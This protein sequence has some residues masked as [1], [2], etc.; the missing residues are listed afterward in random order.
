MDSIIRG[1]YQPLEKLGSG[2]MGDV[3]KA[4]DLKLNRMVALKFLRADHSGDPTRRQ[5]FMQ[6]AQAASA[7]N[8]PNIITIHDVI[9]E[10]DADIMVMEMVSG[11]TLDA[12]IPR[13]GL[14]VS[15]I[16]NY[17]A[18]VADAL[19]AAHGAG[20]IHRDLKPG[21]IMVTERDLVKLLDFGLAKLAPGAFAEDPEATG[22]T[23]LTVQGTIVG[24][25][26]YM[27]PE[28]AQGKASDARSD[29][30]SFGAVLYEMAT[31][32]RAFTGE[33][34]ISTLTSVLRDEPRRVLEIT[35]EVPEV[36]SD[37]IHKCLHKDP[38]ARF[39]TMAEV[40]D[41]LMRLRQLS[42]SGV[43]YAQSPLASGIMSQPV[44]PTSV[45]VPAAAIEAAKTAV[46]GAKPA[47]AAAPK[48]PAVAAQTAKTGAAAGS[49]R[50]AMMAGA[51][52]V[53]V[54]LAAGGWW[55]STRPGA[56][57]TPQPDPL[58]ATPAP[59][60]PAEPV[61]VTPDPAV[62]PPVAAATPGTDATKV[63]PN[64]AKP[65]GVP[66]P[67]APT[68]VRGRGAAT[69]ATAPVAAP[70][71]ETVVLLVPVPDALPIALQLQTEIPLEATAGMEL[72]FTVT[73]DVTVG[74]E[75]V[76]A[77]GAAA[78]GVILSHDK[79]KATIQLKTVDALDGTKLNIRATAGSTADSKRTIETPGQKSKTV[80][81]SPGATTIGYLSGQQSVRLRR[82][83]L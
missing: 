28:Q 14:R 16:I 42:S 39:Q 78:T 46:A 23:P 53:V 4:K 57:V 35:P 40:R 54:A 31:G 50:T 83:G 68:G 37:V 1:Q 62:P 67:A 34:S 20:I 33:N 30:F 38:D 12:I 71:A 17:S 2:G 22:L 69:A 21:N 51:A 5:R 55:F 6:E 44:L 52:V 76:I 81:V 45:G 59:A 32:N 82:P 27:S 25:L 60:P 66:K 63:A 73:R 19:A 48:K 65:A 79:K 29:I 10:D 9:T 58:A 56:P 75:T 74:G 8:H 11:K 43:L 64:T 15:Q 72:Q 7:L 70:V 24:T 18:Q 49:N 26:S 3:I 61:A 80:V 36:L 41:A 47:A 13:G 77:S